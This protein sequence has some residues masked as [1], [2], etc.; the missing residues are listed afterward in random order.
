MN[1]DE[2]SPGLDGFAEYCGYIYGR[3]FK[4]DLHEEEGRPAYMSAEAFP[5][6]FTRMKAMSLRAER[7]VDN[8]KAYCSAL[9]E[10]KI[11][12]DEA[13]KAEADA[14]RLLVSDEDA[15]VAARGFWNH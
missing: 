6:N 5:D 3:E 11:H 1:V 10:A 9:H 12:G 14:L 15:L 13:S 4:V 8:F 7:A 2:L